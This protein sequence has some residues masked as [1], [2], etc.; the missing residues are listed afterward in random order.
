MGVY[1]D[2]P[3]FERFG[4]RWCHLTADTA[5]ELHAFAASLGLR[6]A[7]FQTKPGR[8]W[9]DHYD[10]PEARR[11][12]AV[13]LGAIEITFR[14]MGALLARKREAARRSAGDRL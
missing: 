3:L 8:P 9:A 5:Q 1:V 14:E 13:A 11:A 10:L 6:R 7:R 4:M 2:E 12:D